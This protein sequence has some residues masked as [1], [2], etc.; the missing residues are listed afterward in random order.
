MTRLTRRRVAGHD[1][2]RVWPDRPGSPRLGSKALRQPSAAENY[3]RFA[4]PFFAYF[5]LLDVCRARPR[6]PLDP[7]GPVR[8]PPPGPGDANNGISKQ[9]IESWRESERA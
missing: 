2:W 1:H 6:R 9:D 4:M 5:T 7:I 8:G 3:L